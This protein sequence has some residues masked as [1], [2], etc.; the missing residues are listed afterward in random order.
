MLLALLAG[1]GTFGLILAAGLLFL[2]P[3][4]ARQTPALLAGFLAIASC[5]GALLMLHNAEKPAPGAW[6]GRDL[7]FETVPGGTK[8]RVSDFK[9]RVLVVNIWATWCP[10][11]RGE[12][13]ALERL[14]TDYLNDGLEVLLLSDESAADLLEFEPLA[15]ISCITGRFSYK[16]QTGRPL[17]IASAR[18]YTFLIGRDG[19]VL[20]SFSGS[21]EYEDWVR[22]VKR[23]LR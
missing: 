13:P 1:I 5:G 17:R 2:K 12:L 15:S 22:I 23:H 11:C 9:G 16:G 6:R 18:P 4:P 10:P 14:R 3:N 21:R 8:R 19:E 7:D 20:D